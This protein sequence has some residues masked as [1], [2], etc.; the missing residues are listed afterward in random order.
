MSEDLQLDLPFKGERK[1]LHSTDI[2]PALVDIARNRFG[3]EAWVDALTLRRP[4]TNVL[5]ATFE[6][7][8][9]FAGTFS[10][11]KGSE[12]IPG[13][14][15]DTGR[16]VTRRVPYDTSPIMAAAI[17]FPGGARIVEPLPGFRMIDMVIGLMRIVINQVDTRRWWLCQLNL[18]TPL[19]AVSP[20]QVC[21]QRNLGGRFLI[22]KIEQCG[23]VIGSARGILGNSD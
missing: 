21:I 16:P 14:L 9:E 5:Q 18:E 13:W 4:L 8:T 23:V 20:I 1:Y 19:A 17:S 22:M 15:L 11:R 7:A 2:Y 3:S 10:L 12:S 6:T